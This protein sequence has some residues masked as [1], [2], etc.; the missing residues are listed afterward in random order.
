M[1]RAECGGQ[2][3]SADAAVLACRNRDEPSLRQL[4][5]SIENHAMATADERIPQ[6]FPSPQVI[7]AVA[8]GQPKLCMVEVSG[9][10]VG[11]AVTHQERLTQYLK[12]EEVARDLADQVAR[13]GTQHRPQ[14]LISALRALRSKR[15]FAEVHNVWVIGRVAQLLGCALPEL[16]GPSDEYTVEISEDYLAELRAKASLSPR[17]RF[18]LELDQEYRGRLAQD[19]AGKP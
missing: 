6:E 8:G 13:R 1:A 5:A 3:F 15:V 17:E 14:L 10:F 7:T 4:A 16:P 2:S 9:R 12:C 19:D 11:A 18:F